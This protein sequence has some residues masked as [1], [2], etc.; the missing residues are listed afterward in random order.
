MR[1]KRSLPKVRRGEVYL[2]V[3]FFQSYES[4]DSLT[5]RAEVRF[6]TGL[7]RGMR[8]IKTKTPSVLVKI[9]SEAAERKELRF[10]TGVLKSLSDSSE[11]DWGFA[12]MRSYS[13]L[14]HTAGRVS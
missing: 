12:K 7:P 8:S 13:T 1:D 11:P 9:E 3:G 14:G 5:Q 2:A 4:Q 10:P 6:P